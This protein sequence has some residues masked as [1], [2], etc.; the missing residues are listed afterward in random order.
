MWRQYYAAD[1]SILGRT[2]NVNNGDY[3]IAGVMPARF[4]FPGD[5]DLWLR[6]QWDLTQH[7]RGAHFMEAVARLQQGS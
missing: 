4:D 7:S 1:P 5:V 3:T 6:L 2:I